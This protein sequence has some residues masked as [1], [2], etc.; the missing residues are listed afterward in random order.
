VF[1]VPVFKR[2]NGDLVCNYRSM[3][4]LNNFSRMFVSIIHDHL[5]FYFKF[6]LH[7]NH[8]GCVKSKTTA[9]NS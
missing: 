9:T 6:K 2:G 8:H 7:P 1:V 4:V 3:S 5:S